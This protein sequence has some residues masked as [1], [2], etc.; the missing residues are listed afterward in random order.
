MTLR[1]Y[2]AAAAMLG[3]S[4]GPWAYAHATEVKVDAPVVETRTTDVTVSV[5]QGAVMVGGGGILSGFKAGRIDASTAVPDALTSSDRE[6]LRR[7]FPLLSDDGQSMVE[8]AVSVRD[9]HPQLDAA[10]GAAVSEWTGMLDGQPTTLA[11][12]AQEPHGTPVDSW[13]GALD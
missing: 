7:E 3:A 13:T 2:A 5:G 10:D 11:P 4:L 9:D 1:N 6:T 12:S 8:I